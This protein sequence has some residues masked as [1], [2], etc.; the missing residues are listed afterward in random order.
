VVADF[1]IS[2]LDNREVDRYAFLPYLYVPA[3][4]NGITIRVAG[5]NPTNVAASARQAIRAADPGLPVFDVQPMTEV[6]QL[7]FW[8]YGLFG[9]MFTI[10]G[11]IALVLALTGVYGLISY[12]V[13]QRT[14]EIGVRMALGARSE[15]VLRMVIGQGAKLAG[16]GIG[17][18]LLGAWGAGTA[19]QSVLW[20][21]PAAD[22]ISFSVIVTL[23]TGTAVIAS[24]LPARRAA[25]VDPMV[26]LREE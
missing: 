17:I 22:P 18:G 4:N 3:R 20:Q 9:K 6:K 19:L 11:A 21:A 14:H 16:I 1:R 23:L 12:G 8:Q 13:A 2:G 24:W 5:G 7:S 10:F 26:A 25:A 15:D